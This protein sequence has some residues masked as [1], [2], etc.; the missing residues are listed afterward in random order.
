MMRR[1]WL[2]GWVAAAVMLPGRLSAQ[3]TKLWTVSRYDEM[4]R[5]TTEGV[6]IRSDGELGARAGHFPA[7]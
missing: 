5:G 4:E 6:A 7:V 3:G 1:V 2:A